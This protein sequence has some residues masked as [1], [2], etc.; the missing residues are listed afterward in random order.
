MSNRVYDW[1][2]FYKNYTHAW[3]ILKDSTDMDLQCGD[4]VSLASTKSLFQLP[5]SRFGS[6]N[7]W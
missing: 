3:P 4:L 5:L 2:Q 1:S 6:L 7:S